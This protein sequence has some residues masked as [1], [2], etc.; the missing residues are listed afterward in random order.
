MVYDFADLDNSLMII[1]TGQSG[2]PF[3]RYYDHLAEAWAQGGMIPM[4]M[5]DADARAG[6]LG[7]TEL[8]PAGPQE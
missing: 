4:S 1:A 7:V 5:D 8:L 6:A 2:H 3:S